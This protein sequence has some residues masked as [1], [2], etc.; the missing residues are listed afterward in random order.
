MTAQADAYETYIMRK[1]VF[2]AFMAEY[3][4]TMWD[5]NFWPLMIELDEGAE[6]AALYPEAEALTKGLSWREAKEAIQ[7]WVTQALEAWEEELV[8]EDYKQYI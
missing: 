3:G 1:A 7:N 8:A 5:E 4:M 2:A 6:S